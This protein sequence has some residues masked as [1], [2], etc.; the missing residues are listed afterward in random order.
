MMQVY[1][2]FRSFQPTTFRYI[3]LHVITF[4]FRSWK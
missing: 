4:S 2:G 1:I 3:M